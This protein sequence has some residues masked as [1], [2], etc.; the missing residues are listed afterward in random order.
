MLATTSDNVSYAN[1]AA[2]DQPVPTSASGITVVAPDKG[3]S[4]CAALRATLLLYSLAGEHY[5]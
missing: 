1:C 2:S 5:R 4:E 3:V